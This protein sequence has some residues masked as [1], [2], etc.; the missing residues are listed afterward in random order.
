[1]RGAADADIDA[2]EAWA[3]A[4]AS[5][6]D[7]LR[8]RDR[9]GHRLQPS[10]SRRRT[11]RRHLD[12]SV[13][14]GRRH[15]QRR[16]R[17]RRRRAR[18][19]L[20]RQRQLA[21]TTAAP[22]MPASTPMARTSR[23]PSARGAATASASPASAAD[24]DDHSRQVPGV[25]GRHDRR[26]HSG[27]RLPHRPEGAPRPEHRRDQQLVGRRRLLAGAC[28]TRSSARRAED[29]LFIAAAGNG[30]PDEIGDDNDGCT[31]YP[32]AYDTTAAP[33]TTRSWRWPPRDRPTSSPTFSNYGVTT[34][35]LGAPG[36]LILSTTPQNTYTYS[37]GTSMAVPHVTGAAAFAHAALGLSG[38]AAARRVARRRRSSS[39]HW[40]DGRSPAAG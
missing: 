14:P 10:R 25:G 35:D 38:A 26:R 24:V 22:P 3:A 17:L 34:V 20:R 12:Q 4:P 8:R 36:S 9:R 13:R 31:S 11:G 21:S 15:R 28:S 30:G 5:R 18:L 40:R 23:A 19:G 29:I 6:A 33:A 32:S 7:G 27:A 39:G 2:P 37:S 1:M 16:Q